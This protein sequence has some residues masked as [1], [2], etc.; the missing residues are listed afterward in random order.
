MDRGKT[1]IILMCASDVR[2]EVQQ[3]M[4]RNLL[5]PAQISVIA[6]DEVSA[7]TNAECIARLGI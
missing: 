5:Q 1:P 4:T 7:G 2:G 6:Y 3:Y